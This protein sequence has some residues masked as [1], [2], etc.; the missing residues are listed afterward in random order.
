MPRVGD[1]SAAFGRAHVTRF[2]AAD[3]ASPARGEEVPEADEGMRGMLSQAP[4]TRA[5][6]ATS[7]AR[8][9][10]EVNSALSG[11]LRVARED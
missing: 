3:V 5:C 4:L 10:G 8:G 6:G 11:P 9:R 1:R 7:P 2:E